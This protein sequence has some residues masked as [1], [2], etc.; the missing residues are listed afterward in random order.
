[1]ALETFKIV[2][3]IAHV[4]LQNLVSEKDSKYSLRYVNVLEKRSALSCTFSSF[5]EFFSVQKCPAKRQKIK[6]T[7]NKSMKNS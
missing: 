2:N 5:F 6:I 4:C 3:K 7:K 1:M